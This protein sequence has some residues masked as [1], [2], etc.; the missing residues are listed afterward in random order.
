MVCIRRCGSR[1][2]RFGA[3]GVAVL[4]GA[5]VMA[6]SS[7]GAAEARWDTPDKP[8][9][10]SVTAGSLTIAQ[11]GF[12][13]LAT[14]YSSAA[15]SVTAPVTVTNTGTVPAGY[16]LS[17]GAQAATPLAAAAAVLIWPVASAAGCTA[18]TAAAGTA[19]KNWLTVGPV[20]GTLA[21][22]GTAVYC[23]RSSV[24]QAQRFAL[25][26][27]SVTVTSSVAA[28]VGEWAGR[29]DAAAAQSVADTLTPGVP[30]TTDLTDRSIG[31]VW[32]APGDT[33]AITDYQIYRDSVLTGTVS[34]PQL[35]F[36]D[37]GLA[38]GRSYVYTVVAVHVAA[39]LDVSP[40]TVPV[41][42]TTAGVTSTNMYAVRNVS[43]GLC[44][45]AEGENR[46]SGTALISYPCH[47]GTNQA[48]RFVPDGRY[49]R[50]VARYAPTLYW[51]SPS[52]HLAVLRTSSGVSAQQW[53]ISAIAQGSGTFTLMN[54][55]NDCLDITG[56]QTA[57]HNRQLKVA[58]CNGSTNQS[59]T[60]T[61][62]G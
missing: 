59:F 19:G 21:P 3:T 47:G 27:G 43:T 39:P 45:D 10:G 55:N 4:A 40:A 26:G 31:L 28:T 46:S 16:T 25:V 61:N 29:A 33:S 8:V 50:V 5:L 58:A 7:A 18:A 56:G 30:K 20:S 24:S 44:V 35:S 13:A 60:L 54:R 2:R 34:A 38:T 57:D 41:S 22:A 52:S 11:A 42:F 49:Y 53:T 12:A 15:L 9:T 37:T 1:P 17:L 32:T 23:V 51:D 6:L 48:W 14:A 36:T 62:G